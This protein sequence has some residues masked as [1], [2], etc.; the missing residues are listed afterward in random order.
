MFLYLEFCWW[1]WLFLFVVLLFV[2]FNDVELVDFDCEFIL[3]AALWGCLV[4]VFRVGCFWL[5][6]CGVYVCFCLGCCFMCLLVCWLFLLW[7]DCLLWSRLDIVV[8]LCWFA[9]FLRFVCN[10]LTVFSVILVLPVWFVVLVCCLLWY[11]WVWWFIFV[12]CL[13]SC[14]WCW[15]LVLDVLLVTACSFDWFCIVRKVCL[16]GCLFGLLLG[17]LVFFG[18]GYW[19]IFGYCCF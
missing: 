3:L 11:F 6:F 5:G 19:M 1:L 16:F 12:V 10:W 13:F 2:D 14:L 7:V 4:F 15:Y 18:L 9:W 17:L 8:D